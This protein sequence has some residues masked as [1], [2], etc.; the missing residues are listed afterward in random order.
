[1]PNAPPAPAP[2][3]K[4]TYGCYIRYSPTTFTATLPGLVWAPAFFSLLLHAMQKFCPL[5]IDQ[6]ILLSQYLFNHHSTL[7]Q[8][9][10]QFSPFSFH[11]CKNSLLI[12][13]YQPISVL[14][15]VFLYYADSGEAILWLKGAILS[16]MKNAQLTRAQMRWSPKRGPALIDGGTTAGHAVEG[17]MK[18]YNL[19]AKYNNNS[20]SP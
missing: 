7:T 10:T 4:K 6:I 15:F 8:E 13:I 12:H 20:I 11:I 5:R 3:Q 17:E 9:M 14:H 2:P 16:K 1:M 19:L 18:I